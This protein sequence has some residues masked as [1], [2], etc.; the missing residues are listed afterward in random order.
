MT[1]VPTTFDVNALRRRHP[2]SRIV[3]YLD[4]SALSSVANGDAPRLLQALL[5]GASSGRLVCPVSIEHDDET[6]LTPREHLPAIAKLAETLSAGVAFEDREDIRRNEIQAAVADFLGLAPP[7]PTWRE[8]FYTDPQAPRKPMRISWAPDDSEQLRA[9]AREAKEL[10]LELGQFYAPK[11]KKVSYSEQCEGAYTQSVR[12]WLAPLHDP[13]RYVRWL[14][15][16]QREYETAIR[17]SRS[18]YECDRLQRRFNHRVTIGR[19]CTGLLKRVPGFKERAQEFLA[20]PQLRAAPLLVFHSLLIAALVSDP[21]R[22]AKEGDQ[23]DVHHLMLGLSRCDLVTCDS[24]MKSL[25]ERRGIV[26]AS[27]RLF[28]SRPEEFERLATH[29]EALV[30]RPVA[31]K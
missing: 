25:C 29:L 15:D 19:F 14:G 17:D 30:A 26:P 16:A 5:E 2:G 22:K 28:G 3:V 13:V 10:A 7:R 4:Q 1:R 6:S 20:S 31:A 24:G 9:E 11:G 8:A 18:E 27:V 12:E 23:Y 21:G